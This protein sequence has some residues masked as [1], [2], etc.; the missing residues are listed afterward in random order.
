M[1][2]LESKLSSLATER[3]PLL[4]KISQLEDSLMVQRSERAVLDRQLAELSRQLASASDNIGI[5][6]GGN[7]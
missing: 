4:A 1:G 2:D 5:G 3:L 6:E 7:L